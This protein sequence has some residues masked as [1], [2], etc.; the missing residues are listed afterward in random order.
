MVTIKSRTM[1]SPGVYLIEIDCLSTDTKPTSGVYN[2]S[3][4]KELDTSK[5]FFY[6]A[7]NSTWREWT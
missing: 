3:T 7:Q 2:G 1:M 5:L 4:A 6:D